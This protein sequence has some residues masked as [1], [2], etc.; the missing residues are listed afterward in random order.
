[1]SIARARVDA[2]VTQPL[3]PDFETSVEL[4]IRAARAV[5]SLAMVLAR[6]SQR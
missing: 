6:R 1:V 2:V 3:E 4:N 5:P